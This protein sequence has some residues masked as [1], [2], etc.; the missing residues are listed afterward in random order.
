MIVL[1]P[2]VFL[3][4]ICRYDVIAMAW[5][6]WFIRCKSPQHIIHSVSELYDWAKVFTIHRTT[7]SLWQ[8]YMLIG[9]ILMSS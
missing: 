4:V 9:M 5:W 3:A 7:G 2:L 6:A 1:T 8:L